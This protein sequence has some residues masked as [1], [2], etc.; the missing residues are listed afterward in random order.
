MKGRKKKQ[1][2]RA[3]EFRQRLVEWS[4]LPESARP[5]LRTLAC[6]LGTSHQLLQ[7]YL[8]GLED[9]Q[10]QQR[11]RQARQE[12]E[13]IGAR[14]KAEGREMT[15]GECRRAIVFPALLNDLEKIRQ[16]AKCGPLDHWKVQTLQLYI[17]QGFKGAKEILGKCRQMT[18]QEERQ[19]RASERAA[20]FASAATKSI[21]RIEQDGA[22][23]PLCWQDIERLKYFARRKY[24]E[25]K[26]LLRK[27]SQTAEPKPKSQ[28][29]P[30]QQHLIL[31]ETLGD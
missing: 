10:W 11:C 6:E 27:Y 19:A 20:A 25:A 16:A 3:T 18:P 23:G 22:R 1:E 26:E 7:H 13:E 14:A 17:K 12:S 31:E 15:L 2:S 24:P 30:E 8:S 5:S 9:W 4:G 21:K 28:P 29:N